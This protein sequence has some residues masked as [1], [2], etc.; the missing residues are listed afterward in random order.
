LRAKL[1]AGELEP[2]AVDA[3]EG[4]GVAFAHAARERHGTGLLEERPAQLVLV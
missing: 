2:V 3:F 1:C 4:F